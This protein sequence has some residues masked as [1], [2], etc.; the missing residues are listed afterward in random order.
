MELGARILAASCYSRGWIVTEYD[1]AL[2][3][4][5]RCINLTCLTYLLIAEPQLL[6]F[7]RQY[8]YDIFLDFSGPFITNHVKNM[9]LVYTRA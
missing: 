1:L 4:I 7:P 8:H 6:K 2:T 5:V 3:N 9:T